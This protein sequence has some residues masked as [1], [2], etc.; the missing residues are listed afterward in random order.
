M[1]KQPMGKHEIIY[2]DPPW[3]FYTSFG[4]AKLGYEQMSNEELCRL[5]WDSWMASRCMIFMW[6][7][8]P[9]IF[10]DDGVAE[11][12][13]M[14][15]KRWGWVYQGKPFIWVKTAKNGKPL[16]ATGPRARTTKPLTE[17]VFAFSNV[18]K[19]PPFKVLDQSVLQTVFAPRSAHSE[20]PSE[21]RNRIVRLYGN[22]PRIELFARQRVTGWDGWG[23]QYPARIRNYF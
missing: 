1:M 2:L 7:T 20:K 21:V 16:R 18:K 3:G 5:P 6:A 12:V 22:R 14:M 9:G 11:F 23:D 8:C 10:R 4:T 13:A 17:D 19:G 15:K